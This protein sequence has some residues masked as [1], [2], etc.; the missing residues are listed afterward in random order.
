M[1]KINN[2]EHKR[3]GFPAFKWA[4]IVRPNDRL[5]NFKMYRLIDISQSGISFVINNP[6][7]FKRND[8]FYILEIHDQV[9]SEPLL[10]KVRFIQE[11]DEFGIDYKV[12]SEFMAEK[13]N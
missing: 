6:E 4:K 10:A 2:R 11:H 7:E 8:E 13:K 12:G 5:S 1:G 9:L 3:H